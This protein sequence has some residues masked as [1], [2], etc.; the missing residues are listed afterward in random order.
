[1]P[2]HLRAAT[3]LIRAYTSPVREIE[4]PDTIPSNPSVAS[5]P[6]GEKTIPD[7]CYH[8]GTV[9]PKGVGNTH[10]GST[11]THP[12]RVH[13]LIRMAIMFHPDRDQAGPMPSILSIKRNKRPGASID[14]RLAWRG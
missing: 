4:H 6:T 8:G 7:S 11:R 12:D 14:V 2:S 3:N 9:L 10:S 13:F 5:F 1:M